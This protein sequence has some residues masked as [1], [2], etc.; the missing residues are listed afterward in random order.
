M[1]IEQLFIEKRH[2]PKHHDG[3]GDIRLTIAEQ[4]E[5]VEYVKQLEENYMAI[6]E[7]IDKLESRGRR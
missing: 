7:V 6:K 1:D 5:I 2:N 3:L 4:E